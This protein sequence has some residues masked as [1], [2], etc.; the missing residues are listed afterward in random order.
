MASPGE[1]FLSD[2]QLAE[3]LKVTNRT[4]ARWRNDGEGPPF[5]RAGARRVLY[6]RVDI[7]AWLI[8]R[9]HKHRAAE[10]ARSTD[11]A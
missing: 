10:A 5:I 6:R 3:L 1:E 8:I 4:T 11:A 2:A 9:T 7:D